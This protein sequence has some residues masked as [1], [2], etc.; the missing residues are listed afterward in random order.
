MYIFKN[1]YLNIKRNISRNILISIIIVVIAAA[2]TITLAIRESAEKIIKS[3]EDENKIEATISLNRE[4]LMTNFRE[5]GKSQEEMINSFNNIEDISEDQVNEFGNSEYL[6]DYYY[7]VE[8]SVNAKDIT[9]ATDSLVKE[10]TETKTETQTR[11]QTFPGGG[12]PGESPGGS[13]GSKTT[14]D[15]KTTTKK[16]EKIFNEKLDNGAFTLVGYNSYNDMKEFIDG[17]YVISDGEVSSDFESNSCVISEELASL[18]NLKVGDTITITDPKNSKNTYEF[19]ISGIYK[20]EKSETT[21]ASMFTNSANKIITNVTQVKNILSANSDLK[22]TITPTFI[23]KDEA[24]VDKF[25]EE[26]KTKGLSEYYEVTTNLDEINQGT[27]SIKNVRVFATTFL[28]ITL[29]I[30]GVVLIILNII[31]IRERKYEIGVL[32]TIG[33]KKSVVSFQFMIELLIVCLFGLCLGAGV[34]AACSVNVANNLLKNEIST[35][36]S[37]YEDIGN[38]FGTP[39]GGDFKNFKPDDK[40]F[41][42]AEV[43]QVDTINAV[44][45]FKVLIELLGI[46]I[47]LTLIG[48]LGSMIAI[49]RFSPLTIL[50]ERS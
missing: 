29:I 34:G 33:M 7:T 4:S 26:V 3:Y 44:V 18:N 10:T 8:T 47:L 43:N 45:D 11:T 41:G 42:V 31:N 22:S 30:G 25:I 27:E 19:T 16:T 20:E 32:R 38:N 48:S 39:G 36:E 15:K 17:T 1:A 40:S 46:G 24:S 37:K 14:T 49:S 9:E 28:I 13:S 2:C 23:V 50:K 21:N 5:D 35:A 12:F 6:S